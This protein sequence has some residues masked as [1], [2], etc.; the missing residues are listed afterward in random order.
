MQHTPDLCAV[1]DE[2]SITQ[3]EAKS[4]AKYM[5]QA[6]DAIK[7]ELK[8]TVKLVQQSAVNIQQNGNTAE[9]ARTAAKDA[10]EVDKV[11]LE[12]AREI[13]NKKP[14]EQANGPMSHA[15]AAARG[16]PLAGTYN[17]QSVK[18]LSA[19]SKPRDGSKLDLVDASTY[20]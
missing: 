4:T 1:S 5:A 19:C 14:Q 17:A 2:L 13:R 8:S 10:I 20:R 15:A 3:T 7:S 18:Q 16:V 6:L 9:E 12:I 11:T